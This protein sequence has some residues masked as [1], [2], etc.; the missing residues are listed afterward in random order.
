MILSGGSIS[1]YVWAYDKS[2][3]LVSGGSVGYF[4]ESFDDSKVTITGGSLSNVIY[5]RNNSEIKIHGNFNS[6]Y[7]GNLSE[8]SFSVWNF[9]DQGNGRWSGYLSGQL[10]NGDSLNL[11][12]HIYDGAEI[13]L[14]PEPF[15]LS[16]L[17]I[18]GIAVLRRRRRSI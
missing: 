10:A 13:A 3:V 8:A 9:D 5:A 11:P 15:T 16:L 17:A 2:N 6:G 1:H 4:V 12:Y 18:G 7:L 14:V